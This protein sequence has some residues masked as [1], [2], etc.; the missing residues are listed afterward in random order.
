ML[1]RIFLIASLLAGTASVCTGADPIAG[2]L[3]GL[4]VSLAA[5]K[6]LAVCDQLLTGEEWD[7]AIDLLDKLNSETANSLVQDLPGLYV[8]M[9][10]AVQQRMCRMPPAGQEVY[11]RR[12]QSVTESLWQ[13][14][15]EE[16]DDSALW[17]LVEEFAVSP[18]AAEAAD[19]LASR[20]ALSGDLELALRLWGRLQA[21][22]EGNTAPAPIFTIDRPAALLVDP[23]WVAARQIFGIPATDEERLRI[24]PDSVWRG[25]RDSLHPT[26]PPLVGLSHLRWSAFATENSPIPANRRA[27][28][29]SISDQFVVLNNGRQVRVLNSAT[30]DPY[31]PSGQPLDTGEVFE[32]PQADSLERRRELPCRLAGSTIQGR[33]YFGVVGDVPQWSARPELVPRTSELC[34]LDLAIGQGRTLWRVESADLAEPEWQF[35]GAP[36]I[37]RGSAPGDDLV[38]IPICRPQQQVELGVAAFRQDDGSLLWWS[39]IGTATA[40]P[41]QPLDETQLVV[42]G[43]LVIART[44]TGVVTAINCRNGTPQWAT[45]QLVSSPVVQRG[46]S[47]PL[48]DVRAGYVVA[49]DPSTGRIV[50]LSADSGVPS[51]QASL[52]DE[53]LGVTIAHDRVLIS[54]RKLVAMSLNDGSF[55]WEHGTGDPLDRATGAP[56]V[57]GMIACWPTRS[58]IWGLDLMSGRVRFHRALTSS[59]LAVPMRVVPS[60]NQILISLPDQLGMFEIR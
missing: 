37:A 49:A 1:V 44:L 38:V 28:A 39:R 11:R 9:K 16:Q 27:L 24:P 35:H 59:A 12:T 33:R 51:W 46:S 32:D 52:D 10:I 29:V 45:T 47:A 19:R 20:S 15:I 3:V 57:M 55:Q 8:G 18:R 4:N 17:R 54:G 53:I 7:A 42:H 31:W 5:Q 26:S 56:A 60:G 2:D 41:S 34:C 43:G 30:G 36:A 40:N 13:R 25:L 58:G 6:Q 23:K 22:S 50:V 48:L 14:A 21:D